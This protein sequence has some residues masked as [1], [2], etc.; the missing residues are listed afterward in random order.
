MRLVGDAVALKRPHVVHMAYRVRCTSEVFWGAVIVL[1]GVWRLYFVSG[2]GIVII[3]RVVLFF[4]RRGGEISISLLFK[5]VM[6]QK[7]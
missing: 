7:G 1:L 6:T 3:Y 2:E 4:H 5:S